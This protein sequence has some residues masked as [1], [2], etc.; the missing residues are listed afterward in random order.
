MT[1]AGSRSRSG[2]VL[3]VGVA[4][5]GLS[6]DASRTVDR[7]VRVAPQAAPVRGGC[8][9]LGQG[10]PEHGSPGGFHDRRRGDH[11][12]SGVPGQPLMAPPVD[13]APHHPRHERHRTSD[14]DDRQ[15]NRHEAV[16][17]PGGVHRQAGHRH[18]HLQHPP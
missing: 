5:P 10:R 16:E 7:L 15:D 14:G 2:R 9:Q 4:V 3:Q 17:R 12:P 8:Q 6:V 13:R 18:A 11:H 1:A